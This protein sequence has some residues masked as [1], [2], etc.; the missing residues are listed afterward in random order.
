MISSYLWDFGDGESG[1]GV[2]PVHIYTKPGLY[3]VTLTI[4]GN[5]K[6]NCD[7]NAQSELKVTISNAPSALFAAKDS[8]AEN[9]ET[10]FDASASLAS[11]GSIISYEWDFGDGT[12]ARGKI[13]KHAFKKYG[14]YN[15]LLKI[16]TDSGNECNSAIS[17]KAVYVNAAPV[18]K[19]VS[20]KAAGLNE[21][22]FFDGSKSYDI[23]GRISSYKW[24]F[25]DGTSA[26]G[27]YVPHVYRTGGKYRVTL[28]VKDD[29]NIENNSASDTIEI[30]V[31]IDPASKFSVPE[32]IYLSNEIMLDGTG[33]FDPDGVISSYEWYINE[34]KVSDQPVFKTK[35]NSQGLKKI[36][37]VVKDNS[38][39]LNNEGEATQFI[40]VLQYP[41]I[42][43]P[44][45]V[46]FCEGES[47]VIQPA[48][49][50]D[51]EDPQIKYIWHA[52]NSDAAV[53]SAS[54]RQSI[55]EKGSYVYYFE[56]M[57]SNNSLLARDSIIIL[58]GRAPLVGAF[59]DTTVFI[60]MANDEV[61]FDAVHSI[62]D[63]TGL[64]KVKWSFGDGITSTLPIVFH[65]FE[66]E[67]VYRVELEID[68]QKG[69]SCSKSKTGFMITVK[70]IN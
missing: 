11:S 35:F 39:Q 46:Y 58:I 43:L 53:S 14:T 37:L 48:L 33:S 70:N 56:M 21:T 65:K 64:Y 19:A 18:A 26:L 45:T 2:A 66:K 20:K 3:K 13:V 67:G 60:G 69:R 49:K 47:F 4:T 38:G 31:N 59:K 52:K 16:Q 41:V 61:K 24:N 28:S 22:V 6:G 51:F 9:G 50:V 44:D 62:K 27:V 34:V 7:N 30:T 29:T 55:P 12:E 40:K 54:L 32:K 63:K 15:V 23:N 68:D 36:R 1:S 25:G 8:L 10:L 17:T 42:S 5:I 57:D